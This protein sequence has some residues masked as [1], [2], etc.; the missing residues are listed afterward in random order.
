MATAPET[1]AP[2]PLDFSKMTKV[3][4]LA[5]L[6]ILLGPD[7][8]AQ[9][10]RSLEEQEMEAVSS[11]MAKTLLLP[12][13]IQTEVLREFSEVAVQAGSSIA[14]GV[15]FTQGALEKAVGLYKAT[16]IIGRVAPTR[17]PV[18]A[19]QQIAE[20]EPRQVFNL[21][22]QEQPQTVALILSYLTPDKASQVLSML[23]SE[24]REEVVERLATLAPTPIEVVEKVVD[25][26]NR[27][28]GTK[29]TRAL[30]QTGGVKSAADLL[31]SLDKNI[32]KALL[33]AIEERNPDLGAAIRH[34]MF[35]FEDVAV[36]DPVSLQKILREVDMRDLAIALKTA[37]ENL[38]TVVL[39]CISKRAA[40][41]VNE[42]ISFMGPLKLRDIEAAQLR[43]IQVVR[44]LESEG[45]ID[46]GEAGNKK[47]EGQA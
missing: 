4:K 40:E 5:A 46:L 30:R 10:L 2:V 13:E 15:D 8:A 45:E 7:S 37:S 44:R 27:K 28:L 19:M 3:Q 23:R 9:V 38:K 14:G 25:V 36:L 41:T 43:I 12:P 20:L 11:E 31:N 34:K 42:E 33:V 18:A 26:L 39:G 22:K 32:S 24:A 35:T 21:L 6:L 17:T 47:D 29:H 1:V 16:S